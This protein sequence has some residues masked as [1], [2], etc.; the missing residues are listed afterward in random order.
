MENLKVLD[1]IDSTLYGKNILPEAGTILMF[2]GNTAPSGWLLCN[3]SS[4]NTTDNPKLFTILG[5][6]TVPDL[7]SKYL[8]GANV[9]KTATNISGHVHNASFAA[10]NSNSVNVDGAH[11]HTGQTAQ[12]TTYVNAQHGHY[13][14]LTVEARYVFNSGNKQGTNQGNLSNTDHQHFTNA[15]GTFGR[16]VYAPHS[17]TVANQSVAATNGL[18][19]SHTVAQTSGSASIFGSTAT[20]NL[21][22]TKY[23]NYIIK[24]G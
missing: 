21:P 11:G 13:Y 5:A 23:L 2:A 18:S 17:H 3:G 20:S 9:S 24:G 15:Y 6:S 8:L 19:H 1:N 4:Y 12:G 22:R 10:V 14:S 16:N 7:R